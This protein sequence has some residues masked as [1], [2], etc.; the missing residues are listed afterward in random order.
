MALVRES[1]LEEAARRLEQLLDAH[2]REA[3]AANELAEILADRGEL[4]RAQHSASRAAWFGLP[5]AEAT[6]ARIEALRVGAPG[7]ADPAA[8]SE[9]KD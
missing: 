8:P 5:E 7:A 9:P 6:L 2:P 4:D 3:S 1:N